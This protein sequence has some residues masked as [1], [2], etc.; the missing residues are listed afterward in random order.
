MS[1]TYSLQQLLL[2]LCYGY[3]ENKH[4][5]PFNLLTINI[6]QVFGVSLEEYSR[7]HKVVVPPLI[8]KGLAA[9]EAGMCIH[10]S[11]R[12]GNIANQVMII[13]RFLQDIQRR[14]DLA[15]G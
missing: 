1:K 15:E 4:T 2:W 11:Y 9:I 5:H 13:C 7:M 6:D 8:S 3:V 14:Y 12:F 10:M